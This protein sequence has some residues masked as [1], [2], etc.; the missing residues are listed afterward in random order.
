MKISNL[1]GTDRGWAHVKVLPQAGTA[2]TVLLGCSWR[3]SNS[4]TPFNVRNRLELS[5]QQHLGGSS[6]GWKVKDGDT[7]AH[8]P[9]AR[10]SSPTPSATFLLMAVLRGAGGTR[11]P[12][13]NYQSLKCPCRES[14]LPILSGI[15]TSRPFPFPKPRLVLLHFPLGQVTTI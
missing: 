7:W 15:L 8:G 11:I 10:L 13:A 5:G 14:L 4:L 1:E 3:W 6:R 12:S 2:A 9:Q